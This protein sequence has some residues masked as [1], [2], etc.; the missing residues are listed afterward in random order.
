MGLTL[1]EL[2]HLVKGE[3]QGD[4][5]LTIVRANSLE[6]AGPGEIAFVADAR[7]AARLGASRASAIVLAPRERAQYSGNA[8]VVS[9]PQLAFTKIC[10]ALH[11]PVIAAG[12]HASAIVHPS[13]RI[14]ADAFVGALAFVDA[15]TVIGAGA[16]IGPA[17]VIG[18]GVD[19]GEHA[20]L[21]ARVTIHDNCTVGKRCLLQS[22]AVIGADGFGFARDGHRWVKQ[23]QIGRV[24]IGDDVEIGAN[25][26]IDRGTF[27]DTLI[28]NGVKL[29]NLVHIAHNVQIGDDTAI[30]ACVGIAG[31]SV[32]GK[33]CTIAGQAGIIDHVEVADDVHITAA[34]S[35]M[36]SLTEPGAYSSG[37][38]AEPAAQWRR[39]QVRLGQLDELARR[40][41]QLEQQLIRFTKEST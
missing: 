41:R 37:L 9:H 15:D 4:R 33:R 18:R 12:V 10:A 6:H 2:A 35:V 38:R 34:T 23:P 36:G 21:A 20:R 25:T 3:V 11:P 31:S 16:Q 26:T 30:A 22:G 7:H 40:L 24:V 17:C 13:A 39:T 32:I 1:A 28:G 14:A 27:G 8:I 19:I 29:D 5:S